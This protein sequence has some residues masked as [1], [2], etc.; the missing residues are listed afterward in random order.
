MTFDWNALAQFG[1]YFG[2]AIFLLILFKFIYVRLTPQNEWRLIKEEKNTAAAIGLSGAVI[3]FT[4]AVGGVIS[5]SINYFDF[6]M[7]A[8]VSFIAQVMGFYIIRY[9]FMPKIVER[10]NN[11]EVS[12]G[13]V[14]ASSN[15]AIG[16]LNAASVTY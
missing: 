10:I 9:I 14:L 1:T 12:A 3:G 5:N 8:G 6:V 7:W 16:I 11:N 4:I 2:T 15:I 13:I